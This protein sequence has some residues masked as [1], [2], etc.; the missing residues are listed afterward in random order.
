MVAITGSQIQ[1]TEQLLKNG[2]SLYMQDNSGETAYHYAVKHHPKCIPVSSS[3]FNYT[4]NFS[5]HISWSFECIRYKS[6]ITL[7]YICI[8]Q[9]TYFQYL[10]MLPCSAKFYIHAPSCVSVE[11]CCWVLKFGQNLLKDVDSR[12]FTRMLRK[13]G[14]TVALLYPIATSLARG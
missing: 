11:N 3:C 13:D 2:A 10:V 6:W 8:S 1:C 14:Q 5:Y 7:K 12:V 9:E 4:N